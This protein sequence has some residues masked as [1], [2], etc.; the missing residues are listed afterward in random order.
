MRNNK[1]FTFLNIFGLA[2]GFTCCMLITLY[3]VHETSYDSYHE[4]AGR[5]YEL[6]TTFVKDGK[7]ACANGCCHEAGVS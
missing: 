4:N 7:D 2:T 5:L 3:I 1:L 6:A